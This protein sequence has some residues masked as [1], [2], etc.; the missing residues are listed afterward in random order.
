MTAC[1]DHGDARRAQCITCQMAELTDDLRLGDSI[2]RAERELMDEWR[3]TTFRVA[4]GDE[5]NDR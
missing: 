3:R 5:Q 1:T 4:S 2:E